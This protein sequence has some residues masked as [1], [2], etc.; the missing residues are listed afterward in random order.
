[1]K[2]G[3]FQKVVMICRKCPL[4][5]V[6]SSY[7][8]RREFSSFIKRNCST[9]AV[10]EIRNYRHFSGVTRVVE[11]QPLLKLLKVLPQRNSSRILYYFQNNNYLEY[12]V[13]LVFEVL[14]NLIMQ[15]LRVMLCNIP[16]FFISN[17]VETQAHYFFVADN[18]KLQ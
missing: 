9:A 4:E 13:Q 16:F 6:L 14:A 5:F 1:M 12:K 2:N 10:L 18:M 3:S 7:S 8:C 17:L 15:I 11:N